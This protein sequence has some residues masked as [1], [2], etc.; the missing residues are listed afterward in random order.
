MPTAVQ[1]SVC[2][3]WPVQRIWTLPSSRKWGYHRGERN[4]R[5]R[6]GRWVGLGWGWACSYH[7]QRCVLAARYTTAARPPA[8]GEAVRMMENISNMPVT[9]AFFWRSG[10]QRPSLLALH[11]RKVLQPHQYKANGWTGWERGREGG[12]GLGHW[13][14]L[15]NQEGRFG[16]AAG[17]IQTREKHTRQNSCRQK[18]HFVCFVQVFLFLNQEVLAN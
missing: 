14:A 9:D 12:W 15:L 11:C 10:A 18:I 16:L 6:P 3:M 2:M 5:G 8:C 13:A 1:C 7:N 17:A 4:K